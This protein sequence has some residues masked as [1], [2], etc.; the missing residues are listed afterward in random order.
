MGYCIWTDIINGESRSHFSVFV[1]REILYG[2]CPKN[3]TICRL[4]KAA[5]AKASGAIDDRPNVDI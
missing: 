2:E 3:G 1:H 5:F 4:C